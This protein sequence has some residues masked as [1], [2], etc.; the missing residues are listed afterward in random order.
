MARRT[1]GRT[2]SQ[3]QVAGGTLISPLPRTFRCFPA[4]CFWGNR[5]Q[6]CR[7]MQADGPQLDRL[8]KDQFY[9]P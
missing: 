1:G 2:A 5:D 3:D 8:K 9:W 6:I 7:E 4:L